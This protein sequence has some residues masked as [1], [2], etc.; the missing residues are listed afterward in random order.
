MSHIVCPLCGLS[1]PLSKFWETIGDEI[2]DIE[3]VSFIGLGRGRGFE[4]SEVF[5]VLD[6]EEICEAVAARCYAILELLG[7]LEDEEEEED[8]V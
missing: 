6:D 5:S 7:E 8:D 2:E 1:V 4:K 3:A